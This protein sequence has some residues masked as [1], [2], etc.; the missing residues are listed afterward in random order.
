MQDTGYNACRIQDITHA[1]Y[2]TQRIQDAMHAGYRIQR[3]QKTVQFTMNNIF[4][5]T[6]HMISM[7]WY[8][9]V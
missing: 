6:P 7:I 3:M 5:D 1:G 9:M 8:D 4:Y 2:R